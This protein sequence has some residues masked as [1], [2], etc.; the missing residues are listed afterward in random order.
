[1][2]KYD[3]QKY[4]NKRRKQLNVAYRREGLG[5]LTN[6]ML[7][8]NEISRRKRTERS[9]KNWIIRDEYQCIFY[10]NGNMRSCGKSGFRAA[11]AA[12]VRGREIRKKSKLGK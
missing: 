9:G 8:L 4:K 2:V 10:N 12:W 5:I 11:Q 1:M 7:E 3:L 6:K